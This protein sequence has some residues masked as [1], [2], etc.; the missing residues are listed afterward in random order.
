MPDNAIP[1]FASQLQ[2]PW[3]K[4]R[5]P[6]MIDTTPDCWHW[7]LGQKEIHFNAW[8]NNS[9]VMCRVARE[10]IKDQY[11]D[12]STPTDCMHTAKKHC[13][14]IAKVLDRLLA[15][16]RFEDDGSVLLRSSDWR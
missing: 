9:L 5:A 4:R 10:A 1:G 14:D 16:G 3:L 15:Q 6:K 11:G 13:D 7:D 8:Y 2:R 12:P